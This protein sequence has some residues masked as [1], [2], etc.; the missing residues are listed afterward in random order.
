MKMNVYGQQP[1]QLSTA[2]DMTNSAEELRKAAQCFILS[3]RQSE[4]KPI[5][6]T[7]YSSYRDLL[8]AAATLTSLPDGQASSIA[9]EKYVLKQAQ[10]ES[11]P[12]ELK[13]LQKGQAVSNRSKLLALSPEVN[14]RTNLIRVGGRLRQALEMDPDAI[15]PI[16]LDGKHPLTK[17]LIMAYDESLQ[18]PGA[19]SWGDATK[20]LDIGR[21]RINQTTSIQ[22]SKLSEMESDPKGP[23][24]VRPSFSPSSG[25]QASVLVHW[26]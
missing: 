1:P 9:V 16:V 15:H 7:Q 8:S 4:D 26:S 6:W 13:A 12:E 11:F 21:K 3:T 17:L 23:K 5:D 25:L 2:T 14:P 18:H 20:M 24:Y 22:L 10:T 19:S